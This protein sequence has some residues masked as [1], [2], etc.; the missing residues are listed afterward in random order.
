MTETEATPRP[1]HWTKSQAYRILRGSEEVYIGSISYAAGY[2]ARDANA[3]LIV[4]AV[5]EYDALIA[6]VAQI[7]Q[8]LGKLVVLLLQND[9]EAARQIA[10]EIK[11]EFPDGSPRAAL[12]PR[13]EG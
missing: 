5:N 11:V 13:E 10:L 4:T 1:W 7:E 2:E 9:F 3:E 8:A 12:T 6:R